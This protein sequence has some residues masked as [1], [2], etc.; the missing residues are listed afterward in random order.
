METFSEQTR[1]YIKTLLCVANQCFYISNNDS[2]DM[3]RNH[4]DLSERNFGN[5]LFLKSDNN[6]PI[7]EFDL[8][9]SKLLAIASKLQLYTDSYLLTKYDDYYNNTD[10]LKSIKVNN[11]SELKNKLLSKNN[12]DKM[13]EK[14]IY[15]LDYCSTYEKII[16]FKLL[17]EE[18]E[19]NLIRIN[20]FFLQEKEKFN[21]KIDIDLIIDEIEQ[22]QI[23]IKEDEQMSYIATAIFLF[24]M[25]KL[26]KESTSKIINE[27]INEINSN[28]FIHGNIDKDYIEINNMN[29]DIDI[30]TAIIQSFY[31]K[32][33]NN[34]KF[35]KKLSD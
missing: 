30:L 21:K 28:L 4:L 32:E 27:I 17:T 13:L 19:Q 23:E 10:N 9:K 15:Y 14:S 22:W 18:D 2:Y 16:A 7:T 8:K 26:D 24:E 12:F 29:L 3:L 1:K 5:R 33:K 31:L 20:P 35:T 34:R 6:I 11:Y 25:Y